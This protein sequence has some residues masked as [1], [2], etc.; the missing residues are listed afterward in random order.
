ML[1]WLALTHPA[2][3]FRFVSTDYRH[4]RVVGKTH[5]YTGLE[6][7]HWSI[8]GPF[9]ANFAGIA[10]LL[11][12]FSWLLLL[13][14]HNK[15][16][17]ASSRWATILSLQTF[18]IFLMPMPMDE[19]GGNH[20][21]LIHPLL[22]YYLWTASIVIVLAAAWYLRPESQTEPHRFAEAERSR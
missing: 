13:I 12:W 18:Q 4:I 3:L 21:E 9:Q 19:S 15:Y 17:L 5:I 1:Y 10:N 7:L 16:L 6:M 20:A 14:G 11:L 8:L 22:G 2:L